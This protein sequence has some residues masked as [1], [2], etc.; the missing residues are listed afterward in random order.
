MINAQEFTVNP[1]DRD[2]TDKA[3]VLWFGHI[4]LYAFGDL[5]SALEEC[6]EWIE[7]HAPGLL[8]NAH[9]S[10]AYN[11]AIEAGSTQEEAQ[12]KAYEDVTQLDCGRSILS[13][14]WGITAEDPTREQLIEIYGES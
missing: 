6:G 2:Y 13:Y 11:E 7:E 8:A 3:F 4:K 1:S 12:D 9:V 14:E 5:D 10:E